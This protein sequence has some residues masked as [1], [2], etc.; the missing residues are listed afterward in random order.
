MTS[1]FYQFKLDT[2]LAKDVSVIVKSPEADAR[3]DAY[4]IAFKEFGR[5]ARI[6][7][8]GKALS[9]LPKDAYPV[10]NAISRADGQWGWVLLK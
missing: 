5:I 2:H 1:K 4:T 6:V 8:E 3:T 7:S 9:R 10:K